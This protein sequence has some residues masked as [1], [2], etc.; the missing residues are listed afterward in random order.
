[1][2]WLK[3]KPTSGSPRTLASLGGT[4]STGEPESA[5]TPENCVPAD[6]PVHRPEVIAQ[7]AE[8]LETLADALRYRDNFA[9]LLP[10]RVRDLDADLRSK[11]L[12]DAEGTL[13]SLHVGSTMVGAPRL[14]YVVDRCLSDFRSGRAMSCLPALAGEAERFLTCLAQ[15]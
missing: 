3:H 10:Q 1:M 11:N 6:L 4:A 15:E 5:G 12:E 8:E 2:A 14:Q 7:L 9:R 13:L